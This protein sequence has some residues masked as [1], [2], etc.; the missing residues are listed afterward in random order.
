MAQ[1]GSAKVNASRIMPSEVVRSSIHPMH[2]L[3]PS[4]SKQLSPGKNWP[5]QEA[6]A[7]AITDTKSA[8][9]IP[10]AIKGGFHPLVKAPPP[11]APRP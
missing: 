4:L 11:D 3:I 7:N 1:T 5:L 6:S 9:Q 2:V 8:M 10:N